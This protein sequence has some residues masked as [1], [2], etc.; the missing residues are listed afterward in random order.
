[1]RQDNWDVLDDEEGQ[2]EETEGIEYVG[3]VED[4]NGVL[5]GTVQEPANNRIRQPVRRPVSRQRA[6]RNNGRDAL[7]FEIPSGSY[8]SLN[9]EAQEALKKA[10]AQEIDGKPVRRVSPGM[11]VMVSQEPGVS[12][13]GQIKKS[14]IETA[15]DNLGDPDLFEEILETQREQRLEAEARAGGFDWGSLIDGALEVIPGFVGMGL[16]YRTERERREAE[17][18]AARL[19]AEAEREARDIAAQQAAMTHE[20]RMAELEA[21]S[22]A[23]R[24]RGEDATRA[25]EAEAAAIRAAGA[26]RP[27][28]R[29]SPALVAV[30]GLGGVAA[31]G[32]IVWLALRKPEK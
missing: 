25:A 19:A 12:G 15:A 17:E 11:Y 22:A 13:L 14:G 5:G 30:L 21:E 18:A 28:A 4:D 7:Q 1:M 26:R 8:L 29:M 9:S 32:T 31:V 27:G 3:V 24:S 10:P 6:V 16:Q 2:V 23:I 20:Q